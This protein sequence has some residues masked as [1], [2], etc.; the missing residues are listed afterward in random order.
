MP[1]DKDAREKYQLTL[2][3]FKEREFAKCIEKEDVQI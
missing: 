2:K 1:S 3:E